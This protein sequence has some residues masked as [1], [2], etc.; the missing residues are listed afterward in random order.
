MHWRRKWHP[1]PVF[2]PGESQGQG[3]L[4]GCR[5]WGCTESDTTEVTQQQQ[6]QQQFIRGFLSM[7][8]FVGDSPLKATCCWTIWHEHW[9]CGDGRDGVIERFGS[10]LPTNCN[11]SEFRIQ[12]VLAR[13]LFLTLRKIFRMG[14]NQKPCLQWI[15]YDTSVIIYEGFPKQHFFFFFNLS[16]WS[17]IIPSGN[18]L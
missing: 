13:V 14:R 7:V 9:V 4:V 6:Q 16:P 2:L 10:Q 18:T 12:N 5:L 11:S 8:P 1:T 3:S 17:L 15:V